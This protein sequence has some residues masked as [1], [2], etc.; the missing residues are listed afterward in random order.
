VY[1]DAA[2]RVDGPAQAEAGALH[3]E[4]PGDFPSDPSRAYHRVIQA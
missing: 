4:M 3:P 1:R 2:V